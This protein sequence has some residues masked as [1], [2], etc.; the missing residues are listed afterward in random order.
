MGDDGT[1]P[2]T[3]CG[4]VGADAQWH[5]SRVREWVEAGYESGGSDSDSG[6]ESQDGTPTDGG[7]A[8][9]RA[10]DADEHGRA[11][12]HTSD[13]DVD[14][15][16]Q[17]AE[18][19][20]TCDERA[21]GAC[22][23]ARDAEALTH[24][25]A[26]LSISWPPSKTRTP[27][28]GVFADMPCE[29]TCMIFRHLDVR[30][31][32]AASAVCVRW[33]IGARDDTLWRPLY[34]QRFGQPLSE[35]EEEVAKE[36]GGCSGH[37]GASQSARRSNKHVSSAT[38]RWWRHF[39][40]ME[41]QWQQYKRERAQRAEDGATG[42][43]PSQ[44]LPGHALYEH[45]RLRQE[46]DFAWHVKRNNL[47]FAARVIAP[48]MEAIAA[49]NKLELAMASVAERAPCAPYTTR[50]NRRTVERGRRDAAWWGRRLHVLLTACCTRGLSSAVEFIL[51][52]QERYELPVTRP[53]PLCIWEDGDGDGD[54][55]GSPSYEYADRRRATA[56]RPQR[57]VGT[58]PLLE[59]LKAR[60]TRSVQL[61]LERGRV[62]P[63]LY[64]QRRPEQRDCV[65]P[66]VVAA[67][68][69]HAAGMLLLIAAA[70]A[71]R[72]RAPADADASGRGEPSRG[73]RH[74]RTWPHGPAAA[75]A[76]P[77]HAACA[78]QRPRLIVFGS[79]ADAAS[80]LVH[81]LVAGPMDA[82]RREA[83][84]LLHEMRPDARDEP[85][86]FCD[87]G[88]EIT[89][90]DALYRPP[91]YPHAA[92]RMPALCWALAA[93]RLVAADLLLLTLGADPHQREPCPARNVGAPH[94]H[95]APARDAPGAHPAACEPAGC[96]FHERVVGLLR[97][98]KT[99]ADRAR[100]LH[101]AEH[102]RAACVQQRV[103][104]RARHARSPLPD[105]E[106]ARAR[107]H[108]VL[109][110]L[111]ERAGVSCYAALEATCEGLPET[112]EVQA[113][114]PMGA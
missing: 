68:A 101:G 106:A 58:H 67:R 111:R 39:H 25:L 103:G 109:V 47:A 13:S 48:A 93:G 90:Y 77:P 70:N 57:P 27:P 37:G 19:R 10:G 2:R 9:D 66:F 14:G 31:L 108:D 113:A 99:L 6:D 95:P 98:R 4:A 96:P 71:A 45:C 80:V 49:A 75:S 83:V 40:A 32:L 104:D 42:S 16:S 28:T 15:G 52:L 88:A 62:P 82:Q 65:V 61:L 85:V 23:A 21:T 30:D 29:V 17:A 114:T 72:P 97:W 105:A 46:R 44:R 8:Q 43:A 35:E 100:A 7:S 73:P 53:R 112:P 81:A 102:L 22:C 1:P 74:A 18:T 51:D 41:R 110:W 3:E 26:C 92:L 33:C 55:D 50:H 107:L 12:E 87:D 54:R 94:R 38:G 86:A 60:D 5:G 89:P 56:W 11:Q 59:A 63:D 36:V 79:R 20:A 76:P 78:P 91:R 34:L 69:G 84:L 24:A 64:V